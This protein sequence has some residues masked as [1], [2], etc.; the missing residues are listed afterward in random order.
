MVK[1]KKNIKK[2]YTI[3][4]RRYCFLTNFAKETSIKLRT[5]V[6]LEMATEA[7]LAIARLK[8]KLN[9]HGNERGVSRGRADD[10]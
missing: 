1:S 4:S 9:R 2:T 6:V 10:K 8:A 3:V 7:A 5:A